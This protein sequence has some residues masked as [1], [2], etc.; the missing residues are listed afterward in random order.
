[1]SPASLRG[2][3]RDRAETLTK[4]GSN[5]SK[6]GASAR[7]SASSGCVETD[8]VRRR[9]SRRKGKQTNFLI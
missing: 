1:M 9:G 6:V 8:S 4:A 3:V 7:L 5:P 2:T